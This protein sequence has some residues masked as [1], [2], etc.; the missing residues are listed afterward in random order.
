MDTQMIIKA[1]NYRETL[2]KLKMEK[3]V[4]ENVFNNLESTDTHG[5]D[6]CIYKMHSIESSIRLT[7]NEARECG[8]NFNQ[9]D[10]LC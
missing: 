10:Y 2:A 7:I 1:R 3:E 8:I 4:A 5:I 6:A 9:E